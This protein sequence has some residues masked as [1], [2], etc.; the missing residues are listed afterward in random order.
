MDNTLHC[1]KIIEMQRGEL[2]KMKKTREIIDKMEFCMVDQARIWG[3]RN[4]G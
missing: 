3:S 2:A 1:K 4:N